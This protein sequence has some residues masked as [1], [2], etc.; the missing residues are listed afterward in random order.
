[1]APAQPTTNER[2]STSKQILAAAR[3]VLLDSG[4]AQ[5]STRKV[6]ELAEVPL[7]QIHYH[8]GSKEQL[9][10]AMLRE[11][12]DSLVRR[13]TDMFALDLSL[14]DRWNLSCDYLDADI[15]SGYVRV[16]QEM[17]AAG[18][19]SPDVRQAV[20]LLGKAWTDLLTD[21]VE[22]A[23]AAGAQFGPFTSHE[24]VALVAGAFLGAESMLLL[25]RETDTLPIRAA[26]R[27]VGEAIALIENPPPEATR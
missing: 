19:S 21:V 22:R 13:Q 17:M 26:L 20:N 5:M 10:L 16:L 2:S 4:F 11:E 23:R 27:R 3:R 9:I 24:I 12:N 7:S 18:W 14:A 6:A 1:V 25:G 8:F 15:E